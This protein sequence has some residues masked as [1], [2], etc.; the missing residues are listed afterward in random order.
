[1]Q[2]EN[3]FPEP[4]LRLAA[5]NVPLFGVSARLSQGDTHQ[6][7]FM[8]FSEDAEVTEHSH[9]AQWG[10]VLEG[11][12][13][14][15]IDGKEHTFRKGDRYFIPEGVAHSARIRAGYADITFFDAADRYNPR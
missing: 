5:A 11:V 12:I 15:V 10:V 8:E 3:I 9:E 4:I 13:D 7:L 2:S 1:M 6:I 14:L